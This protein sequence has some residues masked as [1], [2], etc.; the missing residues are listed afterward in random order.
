[1]SNLPTNNLGLVETEIESVITALSYREREEIV[2]GSCNRNRRHRS[3]G[4]VR[5]GDRRGRAGVRQGV[6]V[7]RRL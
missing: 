6:Q 7:D 2:A 3:G 4:T 5:A 1:M